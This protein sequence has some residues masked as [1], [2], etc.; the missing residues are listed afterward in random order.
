MR[1]FFVT[2]GAGFIGSA[3]VRLLLKEITSC[4]I[5][6][7]DALT[8]AGNLDNLDGLDEGRHHFVKGD[9][10]DRDAVSNALTPDTQPI[11]NFAADSHVHPRVVSPDEFIRTH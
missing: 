7:F 1:R 5:T 11:V 2:G 10:A 9:I 4:E 6:S 8:Y 3:F